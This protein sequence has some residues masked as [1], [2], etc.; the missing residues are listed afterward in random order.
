MADRVLVRALEKFQGHRHC[1]GT[2][3]LARPRCLLSFRPIYSSLSRYCFSLIGHS[4]STMEQQLADED[5]IQAAIILW[6]LLARLRSPLDG[7]RWLFL[8]LGAD[9]AV[10]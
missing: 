4:V 7:Q 9:K 6:P 5:A 1:F 8:Q 10:I 3:L 2:R